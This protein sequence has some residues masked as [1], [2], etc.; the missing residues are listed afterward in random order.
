MSEWSED[1]FLERLGHVSSEANAHACP[2]IEAFCAAIA[3]RETAATSI[4]F[5]EHLNVCP[6]CCD[7]HDRLV[8]FDQLNA[9]EANSDA[10]EAEQRLDSW[11][12]GFLAAQN[13]NPQVPAIVTGLKV[14]ALPLAQKARPIWRMQWALAAAATII[15]AAGVIYMR[16]PVH[17]PTAVI[18]RATPEQ[19][20]PTSGDSQSMPEPSTR[21]TLINKN[22]AE[23]LS[24]TSQSPI[25]TSRIL[26]A[27][28]NASPEPASPADQAPHVVAQTKPGHQSVS[29]QNGQ[30]N[31]ASQPTPPPARVALSPRTSNSGRVVNAA[32]PRPIGTMGAARLNPPPRVQLPAGTRIWLSLDSVAPERDGSFQFHAT[33]LLPVTN[34]GNVLLEKGAQATGSGQTNQKQSVIRITDIV[35]RGRLFKLNSASAGVLK[36]PGAGK[37]LSFEEGKVFE[38]WL[39]SASTFE[40]TEAL[41]GNPQR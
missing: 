39:D 9:R 19:Q 27:T 37:A 34:S 7:L 14:T 24:R 26:K 35:S 23:K 38:V 29:S 17:A 36:G 22:S 3:S 25:V 13:L 31:I 10:V 5:L 6:V 18:A 28:P 21:E 16:R 12:K 30:G 40:A 8:R 2:R 32:P 41:S 20:P 33:L 11:L 4:E 15:F 1:N